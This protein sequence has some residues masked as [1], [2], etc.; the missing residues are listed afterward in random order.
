MVGLTALHDALDNEEFALA[1][2]T[3]RMIWKDRNSVVFQSHCSTQVQIFENASSL[4]AEYEEA[5][6]SDP[7]MVLTTPP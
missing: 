1:L 3:A 7:V 2:V 4:L 5:N 6:R